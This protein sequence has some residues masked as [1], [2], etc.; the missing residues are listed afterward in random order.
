[1]NRMNEYRFVRVFIFT[2]LC[3]YVHIHPSADKYKFE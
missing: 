2:D 1:M 3:M